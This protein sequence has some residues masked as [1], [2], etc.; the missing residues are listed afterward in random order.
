MKDKIFV[1]PKNDLESVEIRN[2][3]ESVGYHE[4]QD[5]FVT[6]QGW[7]ASW[8]QLE[9]EIKEAL[10]R[11]DPDTV[12]GVELKGDSPFHNVD[13]HYYKDTNWATGEVLYEDDRTK[14]AN[15]ETQLSSIVQVSNLVG[16]KLTLDQSFISANDVG[17]V[18]EM[19]SLGEA[20]HMSEEDVVAR[21]QDI[22]M[23][24]H[25]ILAEVQGITPEM[26]QQAVEAIENARYLSNGTMVV[27]LPHSKCATVTDRI[28]M[29]EYN[30]GLLILCGDGEIDYY[31]PSRNVEQLLDTFGGWKG[32][33][34]KDYTFF[35][36]SDPTVTAEAVTEAVEQMERDTP[37]IGDD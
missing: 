21:I 12:Y 16:V 24:E 13:H 22:R 1:I 14:T 33:T 23:R 11:F 6:S 7:G 2:I 36:N 35:G 4:G 28:P 15:G 19:R 29:Q 18:D 31:G 9:P 3:L 25:S 10:S 17:F 30:G 5:L 32:D 26:E 34:S 20:L 8:E 37:E 27:E